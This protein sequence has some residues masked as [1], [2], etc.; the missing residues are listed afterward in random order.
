MEERLIMR[1]GENIGNVLL[2]IAQEYIKNGN[3]QKALETYTKSFHGFTEDLVIELLKNKYVLI[4]SED[5]LSVNVD[6]SEDL[7]LSNKE[8]IY[9]WQSIFQRSIKE[10]SE[11]SQS[12]KQIKT[13][14]ETKIHYSILDYDI[15]SDVFK[16]FGSLE[17]TG[18]HNIAAKLIADRGFSDL[19]SNEENIWQRLCSNYE[20]CR[21]EK[22]ETALYLVVSYV[23][24]IRQLHK[25]YKSIY[26][27]YRFLINWD[28]IKVP[29]FFEV[30]IENVLEI[31]NDFGNT[32]CGYYHPL[33]DEFIKIYKKDIHSDILKTELGKEFCTHG[34]LEKNIMDGYDAGWLSPDGRFYGDNGSVSSMIH[35]R[36]SEKLTNQDLNG[37]RVLEKQG[38]LKIHWN[39][40]YGSFQLL[41][42][43]DNKL[44]LK[45]CPTETQIKMIC[46]YADKFYKG[47]L[48]TRPQIVKKDDGISTYKLRQMDNIALNDIFGF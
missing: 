38:W 19:C 2:N 5:G 9:N 25:S 14:F 37:E 31:L 13:E 30:I 15:K 45:Y 8:N 43:F 16:Y 36:L 47:I 29:P 3:S 21:S 32:S 4:T 35:L 39:E 44:G 26:N 1:C 42:D 33:C 22:Y 11:L 48:H 7:L 6:N 12:L 18:V 40:V 34:I 24:G 20:N 46:N 28:F 23:K 17:T 41:G 10:L 27:M